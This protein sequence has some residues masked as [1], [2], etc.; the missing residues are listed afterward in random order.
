MKCFDTIRFTKEFRIRRNC[1]TLNLPGE[2]TA[3]WKKKCS[4]TNH[5]AVQIG[6]EIW[7]DRLGRICL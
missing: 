1:D 4:V 6:R 7:E 2:W 5:N 3:Q